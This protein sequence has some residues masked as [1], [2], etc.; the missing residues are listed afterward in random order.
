MS[1]PVFVDTN[2]SHSRFTLAIDESAATYA[3]ARRD[4]AW[5]SAPRQTEAWG[6]ERLY[7]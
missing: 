1:V 5:T 2:F 4:S 3:M 7:G 6:Q